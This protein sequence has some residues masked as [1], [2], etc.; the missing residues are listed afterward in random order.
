MIDPS[1]RLRTGLSALPGLSPGGSG[2][3]FAARSNPRRNTMIFMF[4]E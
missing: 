1:N 3:V 4:A 2:G